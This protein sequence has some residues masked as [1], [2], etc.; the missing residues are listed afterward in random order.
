VQ[1]NDAGTLYIVATPLGNLEDITLRALRILREVDLIACED[2]RHTRKLLNHFEIDRPLASY[3]EHN[4]VRRAAQLVEKLVQG[5]K[6]ALVCDA[7]TP[8][9]SDPGYRVVTQA[10][11]AGIKIIPI[12][13]P[14]AIIA[15]LSASGLPTHAFSFLG[16]IPPRTGQ[17]RQLFESL[18]QRHET[19]VFFEAPH[20]LR[21]TL[22]DLEE[23]F[24]PERKAVLVRELTK[25]HEEFLRG[26]IGQ[27]RQSFEVQEPRGEFTVLVEGMSRRV[28]SAQRVDD[29]AQ[30]MQQFLAENKGDEKAAL[31]RLARESGLSKSELYRRWQ[32]ARK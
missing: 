1:P 7:G 3:F 24:S 21:Q 4:E 27:L 23:I 8:A 17:R 16:F 10:L 9:V 11:A 29:I 2:T 30:R 13:G 14:G 28:A 6:V 15:S 25:I 5:S 26:T 12:P 19:L 31:K 32:L 18:S 22:E 20:R